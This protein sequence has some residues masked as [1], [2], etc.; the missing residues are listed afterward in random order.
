MKMSDA[1]IWREVSEKEI[2]S[3]QDLNVNKLVPR[4]TV[5]PGQKFIGTK[6]DFKVMANRTYKARLVA[7]G[8][9]QVTGQ[10]Y[11]STFTPVC[12]RQSVRMVLTIAVETDWEVRQLT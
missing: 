9:N 1:D 2:K 11:G 12:R 5:P 7:Q 8:W 4:S 6:R 10:D 3:R